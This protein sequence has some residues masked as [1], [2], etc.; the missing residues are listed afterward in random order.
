MIKI[1][2]IGGIALV[3][4]ILVFLGL[5]LVMPK[6]YSIERSVVISKPRS[7]VFPLVATLRN[8]D[9]W[10]PWVDY[11]PNIKITY[12]GTDGAVG[13]TYN[14][15]GNSDVGKGEQVIREITPN[16]MVHNEVHFI[17]PFDSVGQVYYTLTDEGN[18][19]KVTWKMMGES[20]YPMNAMSAF[21][22]LDDMLGKE[23][24]RGLKK[25]K[26]LAE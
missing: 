20:V 26:E 16:E 11:D 1:L 10:P 8:Q 22:D 7:E 4:L 14:W 21:V 2:K 23:F 24:D 6:K 18:K 3:I 12:S 19:T 9:K 17:E 25:L 13:S 5:G 15:V